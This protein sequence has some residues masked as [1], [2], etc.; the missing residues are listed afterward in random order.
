MKDMFDM[1]N[2]PDIPD[3]VTVDAEEMEP[4]DIVEGTL[5]ITMDQRID[6]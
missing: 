4:E 6:A 2:M 3:I 1:P 5:K